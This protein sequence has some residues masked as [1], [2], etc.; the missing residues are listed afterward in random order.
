MRFRIICCVAAAAGG[1]RGGEEVEG[2]QE[3]SKGGGEGDK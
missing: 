1:G 2:L 3:K